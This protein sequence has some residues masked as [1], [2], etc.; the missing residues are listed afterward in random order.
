[1]NTRDYFAEAYS[2]V[3]DGYIVGVEDLVGDT[4]GFYGPYKT[5]QEVMERFNALYESAKRFGHKVET[6]FGSFKVDDEVRI[7]L[8]TGLGAIPNGT[9]LIHPDCQ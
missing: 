5:P 9:E 4:G 6:A 8:L 7:F 3:S 2:D 1:M